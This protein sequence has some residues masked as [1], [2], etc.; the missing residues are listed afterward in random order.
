MGPPG[1][2]GAAVSIRK[3]RFISKIL[4]F[5]YFKGPP[6]NP[7]IPGTPGTVGFPGREVCARISY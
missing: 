1:L 4:L 6:G 2:P 5:T 3:R 7:G